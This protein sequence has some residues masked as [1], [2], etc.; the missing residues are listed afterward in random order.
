MLWAGHIPSRV[1]GLLPTPAPQSPPGFPVMCTQ[2]IPH[3]LTSTLVVLPCLLLLASTK[4][5]AKGAP[6][7]FLGPQG[8]LHRHRVCDLSRW[9]L[10]QVLAVAVGWGE[11][12][13]GG[14]WEASAGYWEELGMP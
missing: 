2:N 9:G 6:V 12:G 1:Q 13:T 14:S 10:G 11:G 7:S 3:S 4:A 5:V 8:T